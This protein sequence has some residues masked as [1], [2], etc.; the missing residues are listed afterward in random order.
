MLQVV[1]IWPYLS[2]NSSHQNLAVNP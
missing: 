1:A 2:C